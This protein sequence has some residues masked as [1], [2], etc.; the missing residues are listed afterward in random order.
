MEKYDLEK[1][2]LK[3]SADVILLSEKL[4]KTRAG[5]HIAGQILRSGTSAYPNHGEAQAAESRKDFIHKMRVCL[6]EL[7][8]TLRWLNL[9]AE[10][11]IIS[12]QEVLARIRQEND[13][14]IRIFMASIKTASSKQ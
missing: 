8:E 13:E 3:F 10:T 14:L 7:R 6:K 2:L 5:N 12:D 11:K 4:P 9:I 1:R